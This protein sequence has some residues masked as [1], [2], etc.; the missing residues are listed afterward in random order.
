MMECNENNSKERIR[1]GRTCNPEYSVEVLLSHLRKIQLQGDREKLTKLKLEEITDIPRRNWN[2][3][4][5]YID[6][7]NEGLK[8]D[9]EGFLCDFPLPN[10]EEVFKMY[11][12]KNKEKLK[13]VFKEYNI[14]INQ[15]WEKYSK[16]EILQEKT[17]EKLAE[18][19]IQILQLEGKLKEKDVSIEYYKRKY[20]QVCS[21]SANISKRRDGNIKQ[22]KIELKKGDKK[23]LDMD[24]IEEFKSILK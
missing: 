2:K 1:R 3:V 21:D 24:F 19:D 13:E 23:C 7:I 12:G 15:M 4:Q 9:I 16:Y 17:L 8:I 5:E 14:Y 20:E 18:K 11:Y 10:I 6:R 22:N